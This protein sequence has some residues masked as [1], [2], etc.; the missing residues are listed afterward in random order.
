M[1]AT[2]TLQ[3]FGPQG[4]SGVAEPLPQAFL[5]GDGRERERERGS[6]YFGADGRNG[7]SKV[8]YRGTP[9]YATRDYVYFNSEELSRST[10]H[11]FRDANCVS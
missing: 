6:T 3:P 5:R 4:S 7:P 8:I 2:Q 9:E 10:M 1:T 11:G